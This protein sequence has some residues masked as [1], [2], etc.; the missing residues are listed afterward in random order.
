MYDNF[1]GR[2]RS[3]ESPP[4]KRWVNLTPR[5]SGGDFPQKL[6]ENQKYLYILSDK[7]IK[8]TSARFSQIQRKYTT[9]SD[10]FR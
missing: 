8:R 6:S 2:V 7:Y 3:H 10:T 5:F 9:F 1:C 4:L